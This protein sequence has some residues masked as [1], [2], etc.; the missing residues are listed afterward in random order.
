[1][2]MLS[3][4]SQ[5][6]IVYF[7]GCVTY[8]KA[9]EYFDLYKKIFSRLGIRVREVDEKIC[10]GLT[11]LEAGYEAE[12]RKL[13]RRNFEIFK[14]EGIT[15]IIT[16]S[17]GCYKMFLQNYPEL[18]PDWNITV[19]NVWKI[20]LDRLENKPRLI[21]YRAMETV[22]LQDSCY[23][24]R[25]C[26]IYDEPR[27]I[28]EIIGYEIREMPDNRENSFCSGSCGGLP[29]TN[30]EL[31]AAIARERILQ[32]KRIGIKKMVVLSVDTYLLLKKPAEEEGIQVIEISDALGL[33]L[34]IRKKD[35]DEE[36][37]EKEEEMVLD[38]TEEK[39][40]IEEMDENQD[41]E[42]ES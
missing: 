25:Y 38:L 30:P 6:S 20:I 39:N 3:L 10:S 23:L 32:A 15:E 11:P 17:P 9:R 8:F 21:K 5:S 4:F 12:A 34:G 26:G 36:G 37:R 33:A 41:G 7:P 19:Q 18:L 42:D 2:G 1:M 27:R 29:R 40:K 24:G 13:A 35:I 28:L 31:A 16:S 22:T 14:E